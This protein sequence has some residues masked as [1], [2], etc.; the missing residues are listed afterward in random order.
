MAKV[1]PP[2]RIDF[3]ISEDTSKEDNAG[4]I[5]VINIIFS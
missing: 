1:I 2:N 4:F 5:S 3:N